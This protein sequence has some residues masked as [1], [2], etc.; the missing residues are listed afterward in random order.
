MKTQKLLLMIVFSAVLSA[1]EAV[2]PA[3]L[4]VRG[5]NEALVAIAEKT[6]PTVAMVTAEGYQQVAFNPDGVNPFALR[7]AGGSGVIVSADGYI[8]TNA[9]VVAGA[10]RIQVQLSSNDAPSGRSIVRPPGR[11]LPAR[12]VGA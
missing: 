3:A 10:T 9:H 2:F 11:L 4:S 5:F 12:L 7:R 6:T 8:V 1:E